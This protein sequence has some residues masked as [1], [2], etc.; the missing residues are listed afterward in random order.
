MFVPVPI[1]TTKLRPSGRTRHPVSSS[2][3][4]RLRSALISWDELAVAID[5]I[6]N[7]LANGVGNSWDQLEMKFE[8]N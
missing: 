7:R 6:S 3:R 1:P 8:L 4:K 2:G 5:V